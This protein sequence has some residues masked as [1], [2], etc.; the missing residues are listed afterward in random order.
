MIRGRSLSQSRH[1]RLPFLPHSARADHVPCLILSFTTLGRRRNFQ[2]DTMSSVLKPKR[3]AGV[4]VWMMFVDDR[5]C[6]LSILYH[7]LHFQSVAE[8]GF[9]RLH[10]HPFSWHSTNSLS[11]LPFLLVHH[12]IIRFNEVR[13]P[14][15]SSWTA[16]MPS[17]A[18]FG[19]EVISKQKF[20]KK[21][22]ALDQMLRRRI[23]ATCARK[24][25]QPFSNRQLR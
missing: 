16:G 9:F 17:E 18:S 1:R 3:L 7:H 19:S 12:S 25:F 2:A 14:F 15:C 20:H 22:G 13:T 8:F 23:C 11:D 10:H 4:R 21:S 24:L 5:S 6:F